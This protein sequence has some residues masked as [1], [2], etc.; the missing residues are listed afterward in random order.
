MKVNEERKMMLKQKAYIRDYV[1]SSEPDMA[2]A[3][4]S[5]DPVRAQTGG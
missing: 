1:S 5:S 4:V 3:D 2:G